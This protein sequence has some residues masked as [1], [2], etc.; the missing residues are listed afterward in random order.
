[1]TMGPIHAVVVSGPTAPYSA[2]EEFSSVQTL[3]DGTHM[4][5]K[6]TTLKIYRDSEG[7]TR[8]EE[9]LCRGRGNDEEG[10]LVT[11]HD[12]VGG[13]AYILDSQN[14]IAHRFTVH[15]KA[16]TVSGNAAATKGTEALDRSASSAAAKTKHGVESESLGTQ[17]MEGLSVEG[18]R[19][20]DTIPANAVGN[21]QPLKVVREIWYSGD[22]K[23]YVLRKTSDP[24]YGE[25]TSRITD[26]IYR[27]PIRRCFGLLPTTKSLTTP[28]RSPS[29][30]LADVDDRS[31]LP[32]FC[33]A[34][35]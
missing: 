5:P 15:V 4:A 1:M 13:F 27:S 14:H 22:L 3:N 26:V 34:S 17:I 2:T 20:T 8:Q 25:T 29:I 28:A 23:R 12:P 11:I 6:P 30:I 7:R 32:L 24:R 21:D 9:L 10:V 35:S 19:T 16:H 33:G 18:T 31:V